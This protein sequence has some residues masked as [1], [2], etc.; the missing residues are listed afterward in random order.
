M[1]DSFLTLKRPLALGPLQARWVLHSTVVRDNAGKDEGP[2]K[3]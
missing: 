3:S 2:L 1:S